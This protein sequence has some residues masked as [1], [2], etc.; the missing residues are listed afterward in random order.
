MQ[1][2]SRESHR[3]F[4]GHHIDVLGSGF[5]T[6]TTQ[7][8]RFFFNQTTITLSSVGRGGGGAINNSMQNCGTKES[9]DSVVCNTVYNITEGF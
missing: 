1:L 9:S 4:T 6:N 3:L 5:T 2:Y 8:L 7:L